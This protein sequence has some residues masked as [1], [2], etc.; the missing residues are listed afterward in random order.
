MLE[1]ALSLF[2]GSYGKNLLESADT[3]NY[4]GVVFFQQHSFSKA[5]ELYQ[6][7]LRIQKKKLEDASLKFEQ[8]RDLSRKYANT[9]HNVGDVMKA[10]HMYDEAVSS[11]SS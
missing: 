3:L 2:E 4:M 6:R 9:L 1:Q 8:S 11:Y 5:L 7:S 10:Q